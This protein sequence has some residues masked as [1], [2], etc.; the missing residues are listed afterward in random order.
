MA[1]A[2][3]SD[4]TKKIQAQNRNADSCFL[5]TRCPPRKTGFNPFAQG[6][7][8][9]KARKWAEDEIKR[10]V[11]RLVAPV[12]Q[13][14]FQKHHFKDGKGYTVSCYVWFGPGMH[15]LAVKKL[16]KG[17]PVK[18]NWNLRVRRDHDS[19]KYGEP[20]TQWEYRFVPANREPMTKEELMKRRKKRKK[21]AEPRDLVLSSDS[22]DEDEDDLDF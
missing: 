17:K 5:W 4:D 22:E 20:M 8:G 18:I 1:Y 14:T 2:D 15:P 3:V 10:V 9:V 16:N 13:V 19:E 21:T 6:K 11:S 7:N 12:K